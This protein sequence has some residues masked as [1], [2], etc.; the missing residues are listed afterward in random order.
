M[1]HVTVIKSDGAIYLDGVVVPKCDMSGLPD[2]LHALQWD[3]TSG[4]V[5]YTSPTKPNLLIT[6]KA[7]LKSALGV[8]LP[9]LMTRRTER[10]NYIKENP[11]W[12]NP[13]EDE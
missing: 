4:H 7:K 13:E 3:G 11:F 6:S 5:E 1:S 10:E 8:S 9:T 2:D 12:E